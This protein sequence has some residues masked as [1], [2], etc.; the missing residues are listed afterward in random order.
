MGKNCYN[1]P[2]RPFTQRDPYRGNLSEALARVLSGDPQVIAVSAG[3]DAY[4]KD[5]IAQQTLE[6]EDF[7]W[8]GGELRKSG[9]PFFSVLEGGYSD[10]LPELILAYL[11]GVSGK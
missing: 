10:E 2:V 5:K 7:H 11:K 4:V 9:V 6:A 3:F 8:I 1:F